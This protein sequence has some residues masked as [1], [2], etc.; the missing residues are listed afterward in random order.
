MSLSLSIS[1]AQEKTKVPY[2]FVGN[3]SDLFGPLIG[4]LCRRDNFC[5]RGRK[6][7]DNC[8]ANAKPG[9]G[10]NFVREFSHP[11]AAKIISLFSSLTE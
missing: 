3:C 8:P 4:R 6:W 7:P 5:S 2:T 9:V 11:L 1:V 10:N